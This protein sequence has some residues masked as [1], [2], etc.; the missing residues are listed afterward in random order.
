MQLSPLYHHEEGSR[1]R[2]IG[3]GWDGRGLSLG[4]F[5]HKRAG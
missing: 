4:I 2:F 5:N 1:S 3:D